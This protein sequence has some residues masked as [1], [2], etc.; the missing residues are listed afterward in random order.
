ML[1]G[2]GQLDSSHPSAAFRRQWI[3][4]VKIGSNNGLSP[5]CVMPSY[6]LNQCW[7]IVNW[8]PRNKLQWKYKTFHSQK[9]TWKDRLRNGGHFVRG[10]KSWSSHIW[11]H[12]W[13]SYIYIYN[14]YNIGFGDRLRQCC[15]VTVSVQAR[16]THWGRDISQIFS[17]AFSWIKIYEFRL[18]FHWSVFSGVQLTICQHWFR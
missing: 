4:R 8:T 7:V 10:K 14:M 6:Y 13:L 12:W 3:Y 5:T 18:R 16:L 17:N 9:C 11:Y 15:Q 1:W 2:Y